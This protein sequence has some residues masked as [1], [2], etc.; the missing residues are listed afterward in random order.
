MHNKQLHTSSKIMF[1][2]SFRYETLVCFF[3]KSHL[4]TTKSS[5]KS[6]NRNKSA[7]NIQKKLKYQNT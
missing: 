5:I 7:L 6:Y 2:Y 3:N 1:I 4:V